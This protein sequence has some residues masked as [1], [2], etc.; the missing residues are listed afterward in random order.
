[1]SGYYWPGN[2]RQ[3]ENRVK[4]AVIMTDRALLNADDMGIHESNRRSIKPLDEA[5]EDFKKNYIKEALELNNWNKAQTARD[6]NVDPRTIF[7]YIEKFDGE[8]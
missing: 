8:S 1:M 3:L 7:R 2:V 4:K 6:L 5:A